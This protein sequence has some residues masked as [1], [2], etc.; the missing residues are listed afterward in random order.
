[1]QLDV[2]FVTYFVEFVGCGK[3]F[4]YKVEKYFSDVGLYFFVVGRFEPNNVSFS[5]SLIFIYAFFSLF[6]VFQF[7]QSCFVVLHADFVTTIL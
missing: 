5:I 6:V 1:M 3:V 7:Y 4:V 2:K